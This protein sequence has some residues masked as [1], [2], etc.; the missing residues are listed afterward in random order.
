MKQIKFQL[1]HCLLNLS[2]K[3][4]QE[5][6]KSLAVENEEN[7]KLVVL[8]KKQVS[9]LQD[10]QILNRECKQS[11]TEMNISSIEKFTCQKCSFQGSSNHF[12]RKHLNSEHRELSETAKIN[13]SCHKCGNQCENYGKL[14]AHMKKEHVSLTKVC[15][16]S[17]MESV[18]LRKTIAG[19]NMKN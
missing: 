11:Q 8:L 14:M 3:S 6:F 4:L 19:L 12:L 13:Y 2:L 15:I 9:D 17:E 18:Y 16:S 10:S 7:K 1:V 5:A